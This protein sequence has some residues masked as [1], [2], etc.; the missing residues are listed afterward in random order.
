MRK[1]LKG[2]N[3][4]LKSTVN[5]F[6]T[7]SKSNRLMSFLRNILLDLWNKILQKGR[8]KTW[9]PLR[10][11]WQNGFKFKWKELFLRITIL[12]PV[13]KIFLF[14][15]WTS[16][17]KFKRFLTFWNPTSWV[18]ILCMMASTLITL[19]W[20]SLSKNCSS[21]TRAW[22]PQLSQLPVK[23]FK[24]S[25]GI[26]SLRQD[27]DLTTIFTWATKIG[28]LAAL[29]QKSLSSLWVLDSSPTTNP[30]TFPSKFNGS[31]MM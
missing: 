27:A 25:N 11:I 17:T 1:S 9:R 28:T 22:S 6:K 20:T 3:R 23:L 30:K 4:I 8:P 15:K 13:A 26:G 14:S 16:T 29:F 12:T 31:S 2:L 19:L 10:M 5:L 7:M 18:D 21:R 24:V